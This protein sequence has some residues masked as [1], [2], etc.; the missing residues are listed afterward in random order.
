LTGM[1]TNP[2]LRDKDAMERAGMQ[3]SMGRAACTP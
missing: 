1:D 2:K 3:T